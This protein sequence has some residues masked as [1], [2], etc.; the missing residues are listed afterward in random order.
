M[1]RRREQ[2]LEHQIL[3]TATLCLLAGGAVMVYSASSARTLLEGS[4]DGTG[5]LV[6]YA[7]YGTLGF[8]AMQLVARQNLDR[9][10]RFTPILLGTAFVLLLLVKIPGIGVEINGARRWI[11]AGPLQ[12][13]P[14]E[15]MKLAL[16]LYAAHL[17]ADRPKLVLSL[18]TIISPLLLVLVSACALI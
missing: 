15:L 9:V 16:V 8:I 13:Q 2:P 3:L 11:G 10:R 5:Y 7:M 18:R 6:K 4:G 17:L 1:P 12:F 14:S